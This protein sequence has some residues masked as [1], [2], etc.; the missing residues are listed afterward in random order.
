MSFLAEASTM[1]FTW[2]LFTALS[3]SDSPMLRYLSNTALAVGA[4]AW[5]A[6]SSVSFAS[7]IISSLLW[8]YPVV[9]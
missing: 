3:Y 6:A 5:P 9:N 2:Y 7:S 4:L 8:H 1:F